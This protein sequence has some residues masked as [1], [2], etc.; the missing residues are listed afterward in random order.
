MSDIQKY[1]D[2]Q[3]MNSDKAV[4]LCIFTG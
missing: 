4:G 3:A 2:I 1:Y